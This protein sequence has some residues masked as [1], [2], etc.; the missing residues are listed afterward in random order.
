ME[1]KQA[2]LADYD[3]GI[4]NL[5]VYCTKC[6][7]CNVQS[8]MHVMINIKMKPPKLIRSATYIE[9]DKYQG[10]DLTIDAYII[11]LPVRQTVKNI[12]LVSGSSS[13]SSL[14]TK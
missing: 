3:D 5:G 14:E 7:T 10:S 8:V 13:W 12:E 9:R 1:N 11:R 6:I 2:Y 4:N